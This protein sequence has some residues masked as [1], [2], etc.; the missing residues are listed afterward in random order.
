VKVVAR[1]KVLVV[2]DAAAVRETVRTVLGG[3][4]DVRTV[5][6]SDYISDQEQW[7]EGVDL[8]IISDEPR[9]RCATAR[10]TVPTIWLS[11]APRG[12]SGRASSPG[13]RILPRQ[14]SP[15][16]L[17]RQVRD[18][19]EQSAQPALSPP[20]R[21][22][23]CEPY[24]PGEAARV[25]RAAVDNRLPV[26][27]HGEPGTG[28]RTLARAL[29]ELSGAHRF[30]TSTGRTFDEGERP[31]PFCAAPDGES[32]TLY[33]DGVDQLTAA[34]QNR[35]ADILDPATGLVTIDEVNL[36]LISS[37]ER[38]LGPL[39]D[40]GQFPTGLYY[41]ITV[42]SLRLP[43]LRERQADIPTLAWTL[44]RDICALLGLA[45]VEF[46]ARALD[47]LS[48][49]LWYGNMA[50]LESVLAR[51]IAIHHLN[52][53]DADHLLF[54]TSTISSPGAETPTNRAG[55]RGDSTAPGPA[56]ELIANELAHELQNPLVTVRT[57]ASI[58]Q[59]RMRGDPDH[60]KISS[61]AGEA[62]DRMDAVIGNLLRFAR[63]RSPNRRPV[64]LSQLTTGPLQELARA[65]ESSGAR[66]DVTPAPSALVLVDSDQ[67]ECA[68]SNLF[69]AVARGSR[70]G[71]RYSVTYRPPA[72]MILRLPAGQQGP[73]AQ[74]AAMLDGAADGEA[75]PPLG[76]AIAR[77]LIE[78]NGG[79][80]LFDSTMDPPMVTLQFVAVEA[81]EKDDSGNG[82]ATRLDR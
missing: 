73:H 11:D 5:P 77:S 32:G 71:S 21:I 43:A 69:A 82:Q 36:R 9:A 75:P 50:E 58:A 79:R 14:F 25:L 46:T 3:D 17:R 15:R 63:F 31:T 59:Q 22:R 66:L 16:E 48:N 60:E 80:F 33:I 28:K 81:T 53:I 38:D 56:L 40:E 65:L 19:L 23:L 76:V 62:I 74:L 1:Q 37:A 51:T 45:P 78:S 39:V 35:L 18:L 34:G 64:S 7:S 2:D 26:F 41:R 44:M 72:T 13:G 8:L 27:L 12:P 4:L 68:L 52:V 42:L 6:L 67:M 55:S 49:Y 54:E 20:V 70:S 47:R 29:H 10:L 57:F 30:L 24:V 61:L